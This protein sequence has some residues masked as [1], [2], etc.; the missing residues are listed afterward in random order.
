MKDLAGKAAVVTGAAGGIGLALCRALAAAGMDVVMA[1]ISEERLRSAADSVSEQSGAEVL[2]VAT[3]VSSDG[4][5]AELERRARE[6]FGKVHLLCN[7]A[8][9][10][11]A[12]GRAWRMAPEQLDWAL[13]INLFGVLHGIRAFVPGMI[14]LEE[15]AHVVNTASI[16]GLLGM[17]RISGYATTKAAVVGLSESLLLDLRERGAQVGVSVLC[18][19]AVATDLNEHSTVLRTGA[20]DPA[21]DGDAGVDGPRA[22]PEEIAATTVEAIHAGR[23]WI[24]THPGYNE[25]LDRRLQMQ[26]G[27][28][29]EPVAPGFFT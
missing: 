27:A 29:L 12:P 17:P 10:T 2:A 3:D 8:G 13:R 18:P 23:F 11:L 14:K 26:R 19:G 5:V 6:R 15:P 25:L 16:S 28:N 20:N 21:A 9:V 1:D 4:S 7:N 22:S 24:L